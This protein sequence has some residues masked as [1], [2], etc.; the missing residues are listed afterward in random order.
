MSSKCSF[1]GAYG[2]EFLL[3][4]F[5]GRLCDIISALGAVPKVV[6]RDRDGGICPKA[7]NALRLRNIIAERPSELAFDH[8][9]NFVALAIWE[10]KATLV[11]IKSG[12]GSW[13]VSRGTGD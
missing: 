5:V 2:L 7:R 6:Q 13:N 8:F 11:T 1:D 12:W 3:G 9:V 10:G 4:H